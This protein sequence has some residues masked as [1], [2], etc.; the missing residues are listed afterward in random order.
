MIGRGG[1]K[2]QAKYRLTL[3]R[4]GRFFIGKLGGVR[5]ET[6]PTLI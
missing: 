2:D 5:Q 1:E 3:S 6:Y 4:V